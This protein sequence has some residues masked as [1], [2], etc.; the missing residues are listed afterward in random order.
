[1][2][3]L[4]A[5]I[6]VL[7]F[8]LLQSCA[9]V[10]ELH[11]PTD[12][13]LGYTEVK[14]QEGQTHYKRT[15]KRDIKIETDHVMIR[16]AAHEVIY[17]PKNEVLESSLDN[18]SVSKSPSFRLE[19]ANTKEYMHLGASLLFRDTKEPWEF[20]LGASLFDTDSIVYAGFDGGIRYN[21]PIY[22]FETFAGTGFY[23]GDNKQCENTYLGDAV[24]ED[25]TKRFLTAGFVELGV[26]Y[27]SL[28][29]FAR[30]YGI[31]DSGV[32]IPAKNFIG[33]NL[34]F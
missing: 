19:L 21:I 4:I 16:H 34:D 32:E 22:E 15:R 31:R 3:V 29:I 2:K 23:I 24:F 9:T 27:K 20:R 14:T 18:K 30:R 11:D 10:S 5:P 1:M 13:A 33:I 12:L 28:G 17:T 25:C 7:F 8:I 26:Q 6:I